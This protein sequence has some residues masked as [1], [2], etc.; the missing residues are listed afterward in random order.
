M[1]EYKSFQ[2]SCSFKNETSKFS[3]SHTFRQNEKETYKLYKEEN[4]KRK[5]KNSAAVVV[6][7]PVLAA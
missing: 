1:L 6:D 5:V 4:G 2:S 3:Y 7:V